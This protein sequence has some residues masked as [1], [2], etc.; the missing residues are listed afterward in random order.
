MNFFLFNQHLQTLAHQMPNRNIHYIQKLHNQ[1]FHKWFK[2]YVST[3]NDHIYY[4][5][6]TS[7]TLIFVLASFA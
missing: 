7:S 4:I 3:V 5:L 6:H 2:E 1:T